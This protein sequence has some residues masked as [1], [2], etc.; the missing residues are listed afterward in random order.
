MTG[1][2]AD[3]ETLRRPISFRKRLAFSAV[4][5]LGLFLFLETLSYFSLSWMDGR[6]FT[7]SSGGEDRQRVVTGE[8][9]R[10]PVPTSIATSAGVVHPYLG[11]AMPPNW[12]PESIVTWASAADF[13]NQPCD[14]FASLLP[15]V[16]KRSDETLLIG[17]FGGSVAEIFYYQGTPYLIRELQQD[18]RFRN[19]KPVVVNLAAGGY[20]QPQQLMAL[21]YLLAQGGEL[22]LLINLDGFN[23]VA[24]HPAEN[25]KRSVNPIYPR[26]W[27]ARVGQIR[28][29]RLLKL[30]GRAAIAEERLT[31]FDNFFSKPPISLSPTG[32][33]VWRAWRPKLV[34]QFQQAKTSIEDASADDSSTRTGEGYHPK[35]EQAMYGDLV[36]LW[37][38]SSRQMRTLCEANGIRYYHFLQPNQYVEGSKQFTA[39]ELKQAVSEGHPYQEG[40][41]KGYPLLRQAGQRLL[42]SGETFVDLTDVFATTTEQIYFDTCCHFGSHGNQIIAKRIAQTIITDKKTD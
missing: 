19:R 26:A 5:V 12:E 29:H 32:H 16:Q 2:V 9:E 1:N 28:D 14:G 15:V 22:D 7:W 35:S 10:A 4:I 37:E 18:P 27:S 39:A 25:Q 41:R 33:L 13:K 31:D 17:I 6:W 40:V 23:E 36:E 8:N 24:L 42:A 38:G 30:Y 11:Y 21:N 20:K 3:P 34:K